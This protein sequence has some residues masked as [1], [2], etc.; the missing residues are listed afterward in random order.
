MLR[1]VLFLLLSL[2]GVAPIASAA[3]SKSAL[4]AV[5]QSEL[6]GDGAALEKTVGSV[7]SWSN[8][9][10]AIATGMVQEL[11]ASAKD[12]DARAR[13]DFMI[14]ALAKMFSEQ[15]SLLSIM[16]ID[17]IKTVWAALQRLPADLATLDHV[18]TAA[19]AAVTMYNQGGGSPGAVFASFLK[20][21]DDSAE[22]KLYG[23]TDHFTWSTPAYWEKDDGGSSGSGS[24]NSGG[25][26]G[27]G[28]TSGE[29][30]KPEVV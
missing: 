26:A 27:S 28:D 29:S 6:A 19:T 13:A 3:E 12:A 20:Q 8:S 5:S 2:V 4:P 7:I 24:G 14:K 25:S 10:K 11:T 15:G 21:P 23:T 22:L 1:W 18:S 9:Q 16:T 17:D 30:P